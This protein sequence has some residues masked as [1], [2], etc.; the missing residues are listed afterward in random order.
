MCPAVLYMG[1]VTLRLGFLSSKE[2]KK[3]NCKPKNQDEQE[4]PF[5][6][7]EIMRSRQE[8]KKTLSNKKRKKEGM[9]SH[10]CVPPY[11]HPSS[12]PNSE[13]RLRHR[14]YTKT[15]YWECRV[16]ERQHRADFTAVLL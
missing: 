9:Y 6:L 5:R 8:M 16:W 4:I 1:R 3:V 15:R 12:R 2:K 10:C 14:D 13:R 7:R 11:L